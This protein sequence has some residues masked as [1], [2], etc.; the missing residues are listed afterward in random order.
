MSD[1]IDPIFDID[2][3][4]GETFDTHDVYIE[5]LPPKDIVTFQEQRTCADIFR[6]IQKDLL[7]LKPEFQREFVWSVAQQTHF[8]DSLAKGLP[9]PNLCF[10]QDVQ[11]KKYTVIDGVQRVSTIKRILDPSESWNLS[12][13]QSIDRKIRGK[14]VEELRQVSLPL[15]GTRSILD[16]V[17]EQ[18]LPLTIILCDQN[19]PSHLEFLF[20]IFHRLNRGGEKLSNQEIRNC[21]FGGKFNELLKELDCYAS[22]RALNRLEPGR[23]YR[24]RYQEI[25]LR[26]FAFSED[27]GRYKGSLSQFLNQYMREISGREKKTKFD[28]SDASL[29]ERKERFQKT[30][31]L[32]YRD[33]FDQQIDQR[34]SIS[35][36]ESTLVGVGNNL[37]ALLQIPSKQ[38]RERYDVLRSKPEF[39]KENLGR[40]LSSADKVV[41]RFKI[42]NSVFGP[43]DSKNRD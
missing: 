20:T 21:I 3:D 29:M 9:I 16:L 18:Q 37:G 14:S 24:C 28:L 15:F 32:I 42:A 7:D 38:L 19:K 43:N 23:N 27:I 17:E 5:F 39:S 35:V 11:T 10:A 22:W 36:L 33:I 30:V 6:L 26:F 8:I 2:P 34:L 31:D 12:N 13:A 41:A 1:D 25:I 40:D 4:E